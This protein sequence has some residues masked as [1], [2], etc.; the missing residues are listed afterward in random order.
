MKRLKDG[1]DVA[2]RPFHNDWIIFFILIAAF[3]YASLPAFSRKLFPGATRFFRFRGIGDPEARETSELFHWQSTIFNLISFFNIALFAYCSAFYYDFIPEAASGIIF[4]LIVV[5]IIIVSITLRQIV[6]II[7]GRFS[8]QKEVF[9]EYIITI[10]QTYRYLAFAFFILTILLA[11]TTI[12]S[13]KTLFF[14]GFISLA[15][16]YLMRISRLFAIFMKKNISV[17]YLILY[18]CALEFLPVIVVL[19]YFTGLF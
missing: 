19:K 9:D 13:A 2:V 18:L 16:L 17:L 15:A 3:F 1:E 7:I 12:F 5:G 8:G 10:Y 11:Y 14:T 6:C 4:W